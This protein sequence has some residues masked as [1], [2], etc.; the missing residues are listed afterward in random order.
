[1]CERHEKSRP[2]CFNHPNRVGGVLGTDCDSTGV[3]TPVVELQLN[4]K[5][6]RNRK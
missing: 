1:M 6:K 2:G 5:G 3:E 4:D